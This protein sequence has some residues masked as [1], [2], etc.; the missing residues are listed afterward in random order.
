MPDFLVG[1]LEISLGCGAVI[2]L[3]L[4]LTPVLSRRFSPRWRYWA[5][6]LVALRLAVPVHVPLPQT[7]VRL[8]APAA[9]SA[10]SHDVSADYR[11][12]SEQG[13]SGVGMESY[14]AGGFAYHY[15][16]NYTDAAGEEVVI[17]SELFYRQVTQ[18]ENSTITLYWDNIF[19]ALWLLGAAGTLG[20]TLAGY[21]RFR[22]RALR[23]SRASLMQAGGVKARWCEGISSPLLMGF[24]RPVILLPEGMPEHV[25]APTLAHELTH[26]KRHDLWYKLLLIFARSVH[27]FNPLAWWMVRRAG[28]DVELCCDYDLLKGRDA[29]ARRAYGQAILDQMTAGDRGT[30]S[31]TTGFSGDKKSVFVRFQAMMDLSPRKKGY[32]ALI[33]AA[34]V[35]ALT[36]GLVSCVSSEAADAQP[37]PREPRLALVTQVEEESGQLTYIPIDWFDRDDDQAA[38][39]WW[40]DLEAEGPPAEP[41]VGTLGPVRELFYLQDDDIYGLAGVDALSLAISRAPAGRLCELTLDEDGLIRTVL[42]RLEAGTNLLG[43]P[44]TEEE[45]DFTRGGLDFT[46]E[47]ASYNNSEYDHELW[48]SEIEYEGELCCQF[49]NAEL[50]IRLIVRLEEPYAGQAQVFYGSRSMIFDMPVFPLA[51]WK[52]GHVAGEAE[53]YLADLTGDGVPELIYIYGYHGSGIGDDT[54]RVFDLTAMEEY[55]VQVDFSALEAS[56]QAKIVEWRE[57][58]MTYRVTGPDGQSGSVSIYC[59]ENMVREMQTDLSMDHFFFITLNEEK[60]GL[61]LETS[62]GVYPNPELS[63][64]GT[65]YADLIYSPSLKAFTVSPPFTMELY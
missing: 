18:G 58:Q 4:A 32:A 6:L 16:I 59:P 38:A 9:L 65:L 29:Q 54:C 41:E 10:S 31:L 5:W 21:L 42:L 46:H 49:E 17:R 15:A 37:D 53:L 3:L 25:I 50:G 52:Y 44:R 64:L 40:D 48:A 45:Q 28:Q 30:S 43:D 12:A 11:L 34:C 39:Q 35:I 24:F 2:A 57:D 55:P 7:P 36:G 14:S 26:F 27:W 63:G 20:W 60:N 56:V 19:F 62:I 23:C 51:H 33:L 47:C 8:E 13:A 22:R 61:V 1:L